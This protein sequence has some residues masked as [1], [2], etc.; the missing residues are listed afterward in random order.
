MSMGQ[1]FEMEGRACESAALTDS[2][3]RP[4]IVAQLDLKNRPS[5]AS[6]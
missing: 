6:N 2:Q 5:R 4:S 1:Q 3:A